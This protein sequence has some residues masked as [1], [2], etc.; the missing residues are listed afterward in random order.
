MAS[1]G[2]AELAGMVTGTDAVVAL[3]EIVGLLEGHRVLSRF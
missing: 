1:P 3:D 2:I